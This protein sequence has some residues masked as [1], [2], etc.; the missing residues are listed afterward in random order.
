LFRRATVT[1]RQ[2]GE[3]AED[4]RRR[5]SQFLREYFDA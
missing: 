5:L 1:A 2:L 4:F 3:S